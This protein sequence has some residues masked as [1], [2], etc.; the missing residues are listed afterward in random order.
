MAAKKPAPALSST[1]VAVKV[2]ALPPTAAEMP[3]RAAPIAAPI[4]P[5]PAGESAD[6]A[7]NNAP[8]N[9]RVTEKLRRDFR[10]F[11][12]ERGLRLNELLVLA[13]EQYKKNAS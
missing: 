8:L 7:A 10:V 11:A 4:A 2:S 12:A 5:A 1:L 9:F 6:P 13:F 3:T